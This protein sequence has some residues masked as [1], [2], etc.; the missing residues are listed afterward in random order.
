MEI[1]KRQY[2]L[3]RKYTNL[4]QKELDSIKARDIPKGRSFNPITGKELKIRVNPDG[5]KEPLNKRLKIL[6][7]YHLFYS[8]LE[9]KMKAYDRTAE[10]FGLTRKQVREIVNEANKKD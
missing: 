2:T 10:V 7:R 1:T 6:Q 9:K 4:I 8:I 5:T 3:L